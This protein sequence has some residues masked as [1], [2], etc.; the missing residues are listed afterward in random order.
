M[1]FTFEMDIGKGVLAIDIRQLHTRLTEWY[2][3][4]CDDLQYGSGGL[5]IVHKIRWEIHLNPQWKFEW[6]STCTVY[7]FHSPVSATCLI[8]C[9][10][11]HNLLPLC[12]GKR[13][14][15]YLVWLDWICFIFTP[16]YRLSRLQMQSGTQKINKLNEIWVSTFNVCLCWF[17]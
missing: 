8:D 12:T 4:R 14:E 2:R 16:Y 13:W 17:L 3:W 7:T 5:E 11:L 10:I 6:K 15:C 1:S 9:V